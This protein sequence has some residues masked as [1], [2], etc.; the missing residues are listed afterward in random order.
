MNDKATPQMPIAITN[1]EAEK[2]MCPSLST[3]DD[4]GKLTRFNCVHEECVH[5]YMILKD[6]CDKLGNGLGRC[7]LHCRYSGEGEA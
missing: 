6:G 7:L 4:S 5:W 3:I 1:R 2:K